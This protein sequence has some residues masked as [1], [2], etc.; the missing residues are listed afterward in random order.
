METSKLNEKLGQ[1]HNGSF[2]TLI[3]AKQIKTRDGSTVVKT[4]RMTVRIGLAYANLSENIGK[5]TGP[6]PNGQKWVDNLKLLESKEGRLMLRVYPTKNPRH[7]ARSEFSR[8][9]K[10]TTMEELIDLGVVAPSSVI[11]YGGQPAC[12]SLFV[13]QII[14]IR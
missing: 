2:H 5:E 1:I 13:D 10:P 9:G 3:Y 7:K 6:L 11:S 14:E 8:D 4:T 12:M